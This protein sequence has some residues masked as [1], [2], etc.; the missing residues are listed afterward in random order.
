MAKQTKREEAVAVLKDL[1]VKNIGHGG[2]PSDG[3]G[4]F[5]VR[6]ASAWGVDASLDV[7]D[8]G[9]KLEVTVGW[10]SSTY[11]PA[12][13]RAAAVHGHAADLACLLEARIA[14]FGKIVD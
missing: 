7:R 4:G 2:L 11:F 10:S 12:Q 9:E 13:A 8:W 6:W 5:S 3:V 14:G 1:A